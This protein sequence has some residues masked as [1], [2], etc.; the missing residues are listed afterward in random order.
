MAL[1]FRG[2]FG[3]NIFDELIAGIGFKPSAHGEPFGRLVSILTVLVSQNHFNDIIAKAT[4]RREKFWKHE[5]VGDL[6]SKALLGN[7][8]RRR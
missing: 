2:Q 7:I 6:V 8:F 5:K 3:S 4:E 1:R